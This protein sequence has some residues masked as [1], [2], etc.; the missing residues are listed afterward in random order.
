MTQVNRIAFVF[1]KALQLFDKSKTYSCSEC[2]CSIVPLEAT[3]CPVCGAVI[4][5][6][7]GEDR[8]PAK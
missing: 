5:V 2:R 7:G 1:E 8:T 4:E 6:I 3:K